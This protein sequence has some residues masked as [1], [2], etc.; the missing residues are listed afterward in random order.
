MSRRMRPWLCLVA[1]A[2]LAGCASASGASSELES[3]SAIEAAIKQHYSGNASERHGRCLH[4]YIEAITG[5][6]VLE[7]SEYLVADVRYRFRD[8]LRDDDAEDQA[9][10]PCTGFAERRFTIARTE[11]G[12]E[13]V[14]MTGETEEAYVR[15]LFRDLFF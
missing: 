3:K 9:G 14:D 7:D 1:G 6:E 11:D 12:P 5:I 4:P 10:V 8:R 15:K 2:V 13:V